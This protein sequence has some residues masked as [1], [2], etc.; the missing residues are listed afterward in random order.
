VP[1]VPVI[2]GASVS[3]EEL[4]LG[5]ADGTRFAAFAATPGQ[6]GRAGI[7]VLPDVRGL[8]RFYEELA[9]RFAER[10]HAAIAFDYFGRTAGVDKRP[11]D[12]DYMPL[13]QQL[14]QEQVQADVAAEGAQIADAG[15]DVGLHLLLRELLHEWLVVP[16][17]RPLVDAGRAAEGV[18]RDRGV[19]ALGEAQR[20]LLVEAV[21][22]ADVRQDHDAGRDVTVRNGA[23]GGEAIAVGAPEDEV[24]VR[25]G[26]TRDPWDRRLGVDVEAH[27]D[28]SLREEAPAVRR[29]LKAME[30]ES[31]REEMNAAIQAQRERGNVP[32]SMLPPEDEPP[33]QSPA[34]AEP[35]TPE[36]EPPAPQRGLLARLL[37]R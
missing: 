2:A 29:T 5:A 33:V 34:P 15:R 16:V 37:G 26:G 18:E 3:Y 32:K 36:P 23:E 14:T 12:W 24:V 8:H 20:E 4:V 35:P 13:V 7:V 22:A 6:L 19:A 9:L 31:Q 1:P 28:A 21:E 10:G 30:D 27:C 11:D 17:V 25:D